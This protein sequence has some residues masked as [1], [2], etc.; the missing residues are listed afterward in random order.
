M[1]QLVSDRIGTSV[2]FENDRVRVWEMMLEPGESSAL[3]E[4]SN[5]YVVIYTGDSEL[6]VAFEGQQPYRGSFDSGYVG[7]F[8]VGGKGTPH[9]ITNVDDEPHRHFIVELIGAS[10]SDRELPPVENDRVH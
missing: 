3:H 8:V 7:Y 1:T 2:L 5:D 6:E 4:H 9:R 10:A